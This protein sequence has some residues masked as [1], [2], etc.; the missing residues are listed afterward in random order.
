MADYT[1]DINGAYTDILDAGT[2]ATLSRVEST[3]DEVEGVPVVTA[4]QTDSVAVVQLPASTAL[5]QQFENQI[6][7]DYKKG[8][9]RFFYTAAKGMTFEPGPGDLLFFISTVWELAGAT[10]LNPDGVQPII[11]IFAVRVSNLVALPVVP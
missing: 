10:P 1:E 6:I 5:S 8:K 7:E 9:I 2:L 11:Y 4:V 3:Y